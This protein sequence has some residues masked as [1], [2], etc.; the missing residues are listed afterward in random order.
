MSADNPDD[1]LRALQL[2]DG[3]LVRR[4][5]KGSNYTSPE[6]GLAGMSKLAGEDRLKSHAAIAR[7]LLADNP[8]KELLG[9]L[10]AAF[11]P[12]GDPNAGPVKAVV[13]FRGHN[14]LNQQVHAAHLLVEIQSNRASG[15]S[16]EAAQ[17]VVDQKHGNRGSAKS[18][19]EAPYWR[20]M[21]ANIERAIPLPEK[22]RR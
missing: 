22:G 12:E 20:E 21:R 2:F 4:R 6:E 3:K 9:R 11:A 13:N 8:P 14:V 19:W 1:L 7:L 10:A 17:A 18:I 16:L 5:K 15:M